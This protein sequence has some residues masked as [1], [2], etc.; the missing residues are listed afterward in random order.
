MDIVE[1]LFESDAASA[2]TNEAAR[3]IEAQRKTIDKAER[4]EVLLGA[5]LQILKKQ[6]NSIYVLNFFTETAFY[7]EAECDGFCIFEEIEELLND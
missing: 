7:D 6:A 5:V 2:L 4:M 3:L 1:R